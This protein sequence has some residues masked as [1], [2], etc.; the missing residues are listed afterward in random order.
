MPNSGLWSGSDSQNIVFEMC[1]VFKKHELV[2]NIKTSHHGQISIYPTW[3]KDALLGKWKLV[4]TN[5]LSILME[6]LFF[7]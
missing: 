4:Q 7:P 1:Y 2:A 5:R 6:N 3:V